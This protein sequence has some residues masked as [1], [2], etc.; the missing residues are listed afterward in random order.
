[1]I[2]RQNSPRRLLPRCW[3]RLTL[4]ECALQRRGTGTLWIVFPTESGE[5]GS[6]SEELT[7]A[8]QEPESF[9]ATIEQG[10]E[11]NIIEN[12]Q[13]FATAGNELR[14]HS[15]DDYGVAVLAEQ[16]EILR[17]TVNA[18]DRQYANNVRGR[19]INFKDRVAYAVVREK[20]A[21]RIADLV[22]SLREIRSADPT[23]G[24]NP[25]ECNSWNPDDDQGPEFSKPAP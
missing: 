23:T 8:V 7:A 11:L 16:I 18:L 12:L 15:I 1:M 4:H 22:G 2:R 19:K 6:M 5:D 20:I 24:A 17:S 13:A 3:P 25:S 14:K 10:C 21:S 9:S